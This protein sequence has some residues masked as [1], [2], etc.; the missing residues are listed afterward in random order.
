MDKYRFVDVNLRYHTVGELCR[1]LGISRSSYYEWKTRKPGKRQTSNQRLSRLILWL[2]EKY[3]ALG[4]ESI[5]HILHRKY[6]CSR[7]RVH[8]I[9]KRLNVHSVRKRAFRVTTNSN[10][11]HPIAPNR[12]MRNFHADKPNQVWV[13]DITYT[14]TGEGWLY[15]AVVKDLCT[16][17]VVGYA[18]SEHIDTELTLEA[19]RMAWRRHKP[20]HGLIFH[21]DRGV[22][23]AAIAYRQQLRNFHMV[24]S[25]SRK[26]DPY[27]NAVAENFFSCLK[28]ELV[29]LTRFDSRIQAQNAIFT[30][31]EG[32]YNTFRPH[33]AIGWIAPKE[34]AATLHSTPA[35]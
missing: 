10:H 13:G 25:M 26:G 4:L 21:S 29:H 22:Q 30:Y 6:Q 34:F 33:S 2:H 20:G 32:F 1:T 31:I 16:K 28:C 8:R 27:D 24:Q 9:M 14:P 23:Y 3:P 35:A 7:G 19:L 12:L 5:Y 18:F 11:N 15:L 17:M